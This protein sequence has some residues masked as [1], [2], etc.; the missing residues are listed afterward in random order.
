L[1]V[2]PLGSAPVSVKEDVGVPVV[3][4][5]NV[6]AAPTANAVLFALVILGAVPPP[7]VVGLNAATPAAQKSVDLSVALADATP[8]VACI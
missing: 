6:A 5:V 4:T 1:N 7:C 2:K 8:A 3:V